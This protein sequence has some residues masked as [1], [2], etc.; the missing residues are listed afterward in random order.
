MS[1]QR[2]IWIRQPKPSKP[3]RARAQRPDGTAIYSPIFGREH[4]Q[5]PPK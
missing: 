3:V 5:D 2:T 1:R 4:R